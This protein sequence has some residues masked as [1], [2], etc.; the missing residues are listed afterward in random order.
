[1]GNIIFGVLT[2]GISYAFLYWG[3]QKITASMRMIILATGPLLTMLFAVAHRVERFQWWALA[4]AMTA[5]GGIILAVSQDLGTSIPVMSLLAVLAG[6]AC[7]A[8]G[9][10]LFKLFPK[11]DPLATNTIS[12]TTGAILLLLV[13]LLAGES[14]SLPASLTTWIAVAYL[15]VAGSVILFYLYLVV[16]VRWT[17]TAT[18]YAFLLFPVATVL[19]AA[20]LSGE[21]IT[22][23]FIAGGLVVLL[24]VWL[25]AIRKSSQGQ[26]ESDQITQSGEDLDFP[27]QPGRA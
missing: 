1:M 18:S 22:V 11:S 19:I 9:T 20:W 4:G 25:G 6:A 16:L 12:T 27:P 13:S 26:R 3:L 5:L 21:T 7:I 17:A 8:E 15:A 2:V 24:G 23:R 14:W 10:V